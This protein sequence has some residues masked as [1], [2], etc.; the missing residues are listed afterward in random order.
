MGVQNK[1][2]EPAPK[3]PKG[4]G[5]G[6]CREQRC[7]GSGSEREVRGNTGGTT[8]SAIKER[9]AG[10]VCAAGGRIVAGTALERSTV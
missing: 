8:H 5:D 4:I 2:D 6:D 10:V 3:H 1:T 7:V 9:K